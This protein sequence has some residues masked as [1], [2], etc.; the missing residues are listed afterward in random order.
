[1]TPAL[2]RGRR[3]GDPGVTRQAILTA[4]RATF[5]G[6]GY[7]RATIRSIATRAGVDPALVHHYFGSK[8]DL[9]AS[10]HQYPVSPTKVRDALAGGDGTMG[11]RVTRLMLEAD[12]VSSEPFEALVRAAMSNYK[13]RLMLRRFIERGVLDSAASHLDVP[14]ARLRVALAGSHLMGL[15]VMRRVIGVDVAASTDL[16]TMIKTVAPV[17]DHY[18]T[19]DLTRKPAAAAAAAAG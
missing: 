16:E 18:L 14:D 10:A 1:V 5:A 7:E 11:E 8:E 4:A 17:I 13:A 9:F 12:R 2:R 19:G 6:A 15:F 3:P